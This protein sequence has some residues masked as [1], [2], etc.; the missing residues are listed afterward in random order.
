MFW[1]I[2]MRSLSTPS[3]CTQPDLVKIEPHASPRNDRKS[4]QEICVPFVRLMYTQASIRKGV[5]AF[6]AAFAD[7]ESGRQ[8]PDLRATRSLI[9][10]FEFIA[11]APHCRLKKPAPH[12]SVA[13]IRFR[14]ELRKTKAHMVTL[15]RDGQ[16]LLSKIVIHRREKRLAERG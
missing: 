16:S 9:F 11:F 15:L 5:R 6:L 7:S 12:D 3:S 1:Q 10:D 2:R 4:N 13:V 8:N 14:A